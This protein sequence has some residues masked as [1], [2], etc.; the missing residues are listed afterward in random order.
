MK[1]LKITVFKLWSSPESLSPKQIKKNYFEEQTDMLLFE[2]Q[3]S[4]NPNYLTF[5]GIMK[6]IN[7]FVKG[8]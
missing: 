8:I 1:N 3:H 6:T 5:V 4:F 7:S 2:D